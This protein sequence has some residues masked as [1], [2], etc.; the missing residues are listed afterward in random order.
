MIPI[1]ELLTFIN[2]GYGVLQSSLNITAFVRLIQKCDPLSISKFAPFLAR[3]GLLECLSICDSDSS[4]TAL[5]TGRK[6]T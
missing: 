5:L 2:S 6:L 1:A 4:I 3:D